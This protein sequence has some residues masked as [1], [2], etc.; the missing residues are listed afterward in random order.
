MTI[1]QDNVMIGHRVNPLSTAGNDNIFIG[2]L[3]GSNAGGLTNSTA[4]G[5]SARVENSNHMILGN[6][7]VNVGIGLSADVTGPQN[8][9]EINTGA[10]ASNPA[11]AVG[12]ASR[13][14]G[15]TTNYGGRFNANGATGVN[16]GIRASATGSGPGP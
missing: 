5:A 6:N 12:L 8:K 14:E 1:G 13:V 2:H 7:L 9:L 16:Y 15:A 3:S 11:L 4:I 10:V